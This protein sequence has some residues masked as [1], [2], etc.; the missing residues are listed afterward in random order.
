MTSLDDRNGHRGPRRELSIL[1]VQARPVPGDPVATQDVF[2]AEAR[3]LRK[4]FP[5]A[6]L[7]LYPEL[8]LSGLQAFGSPPAGDPKQRL[9]EPI[10]GPLTDRLC[11]LARELEIWLVPGSLYETGENGN[12][13]NTAIAI[14]PAGDIVAKYRKIFP[15]RPWE[16]LA[17][18]SEVVA[19]DI[20]G[21]CRVGLM[22]CYDGWFPEVSRNLAWMGAEVIL[23]PSAT[24]TNDRPQEVVLARAN[25]IVNQLY[26]VNINAAGS[27]GLGLSVVADPEGRIVYQAGDGEEII[28]INLN[29]DNVAGVREHGSVGLGSRPLEQFGA[30]GT[31]IRW[32][33]YHGVPRGEHVRPTTDVARPESTAVKAG[34]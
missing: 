32:P 29:L 13:Y 7:M 24:T 33:A 17:S 21:V 4:M 1:A 27:P 34:G 23:H 3:R 6:H 16:K 18:G 5:G 22:I 26:V 25:A 2:V 31:S 15:W 19:F 28:P 30:D 12:V 8:H 9:D 14:N 10:P 20:P 11:A